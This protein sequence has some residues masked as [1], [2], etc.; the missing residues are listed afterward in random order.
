MGVSKSQ[1][2]FTGDRNFYC[3]CLKNP[4]GMVNF[5]IKHFTGDT[6]ILIFSMGIVNI[7]V[8]MDFILIFTGDGFLDQFFRTVSAI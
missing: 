6:N 1:L 7:L 3:F 5:I 4:V 2:C 8:E